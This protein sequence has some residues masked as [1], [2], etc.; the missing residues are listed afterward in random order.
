[1]VIAHTRHLNAF[2][3]IVEIIL[4]ELEVL[5]VFGELLL[6]MLLGMLLEF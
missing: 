4:G 2:G 3:S 1:M 6:G 5:G